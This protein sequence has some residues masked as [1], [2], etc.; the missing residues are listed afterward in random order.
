[1]GNKFHPEEDSNFL[2]Y[3]DANSLYGWAM[4]QPLPTRGLKWVDPRELTHD[5]ID[6]YANCDSK[7]YLLEVDVRFLMTY[8]ICITTIC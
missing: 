4:S 6:S 3:L 1:M 5:K 8:M 7:G 2:Q